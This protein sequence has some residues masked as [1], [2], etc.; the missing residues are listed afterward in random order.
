MPERKQKT[1]RQPIFKSIN[2][3]KHHSLFLSFSP[4]NRYSLH[5]HSVV[6]DKHSS[7][8]LE[9]YLFESRVIMNLTHADFFLRLQRRHFACA[10]FSFEQMFIS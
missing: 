1:E 5:R 3:L 10:V 2:N 6:S 4:F 9:K 7:A 8:S